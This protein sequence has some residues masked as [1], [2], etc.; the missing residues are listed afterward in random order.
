MRVLSVQE[1]TVVGGGW[2]TLLGRA[3]TFL[4]GV[5]A[6]WYAEK[7]MDKMSNDNDESERSQLLQKLSEVCEKNSLHYTENADGTIVV[8]CNIGK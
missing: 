4:A 8:S 7:Q 6:T 5:V 3:A 2:I 1:Q